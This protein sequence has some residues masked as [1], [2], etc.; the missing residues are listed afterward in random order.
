MASHNKS[1]KIK[2]HRGFDMYCRRSKYEHTVNLI[3]LSIRF[4]SKLFKLANFLINSNLIASTLKWHHQNEKASERAHLDLNKTLPT[5]LYKSLKRALRTRFSSWR[6]LTS[7]KTEIAI[8]VRITG[9]A[10]VSLPGCL[11][12]YMSL[13]RNPAFGLFWLCRLIRSFPEEPGTFNGEST[14]IEP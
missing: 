6:F 11:S 4:Q 1:E 8:A 2:L 10:F 9:K 13:A 12:D 14:S 7:R 3:E 5:S